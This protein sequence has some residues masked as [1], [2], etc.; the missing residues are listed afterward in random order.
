M[1]RGKHRKLKDRKDAR[2]RLE[3]L[4]DL[5]AR[6]EGLTLQLAQ[7]SE[8]VEQLRSTRDRL[9]SARHEVYA[10][11]W[12]AEVE[13]LTRECE[14]WTARLRTAQRGVDAVMRRSGKRLKANIDNLMPKGGDQTFNAVQFQ[15][16][17]E[18][19]S[20]E[21]GVVDFGEVIEAMNGAVSVDEAAE[22]AVGHL[23]PSQAPDNCREP[24]PCDSPSPT[25]RSHTTQYHQCVHRPDERP[26]SPP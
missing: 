23:R 3:E 13:H 14:A 19:M 15:V 9:L 20:L 6:E 22:Q 2:R 16:I 7:L 5:A 26:P 25:V 8:E 21:A 1:A 17:S 12:F 11:P 24:H 10:S 4:Q 18:M